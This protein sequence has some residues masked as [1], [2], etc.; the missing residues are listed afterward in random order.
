MEDERSG[1]TRR[2]MRI[3]R[4]DV[5]ALRSRLS[6]LHKLRVR[7]ERLRNRD[8]APRPC[9]RWLPEAVAHIDAVHREAELAAEELAVQTEELASVAQGPSAEHGLFR[10]TFESMPDALIVTDRTGAIQEANA[11]ACAMLGGNS[12]LIRGRAFTHFMMSAD[13]DTFASALEAVPQVEAVVRMRGAGGSF[14]VV[15]L[16]GARLG[17]DRLL[18]IA[19]RS[20][21]FRSG[22]FERP[23]LRTTRIEPAAPLPLE[24]DSHRVKRA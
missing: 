2:M 5:D 19:S 14:I 15:R 12:G 24:N 18:W 4:A 6:E 8:P 3:S 11:A 16:R 9:G 7:L 20:P 23:P 22:V 21:A 1:S 10:E 13:R 17:A